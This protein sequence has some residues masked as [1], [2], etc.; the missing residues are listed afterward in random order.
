MSVPRNA[1]CPCGSG[2]KYK[3]CCLRSGGVEAKRPRKAAALIAGIAVVL[4]IVLG[5]VVGRE[6]GGLVGAVGLVIAGLY[7]WLAAPPASR[8]GGDPGAIRFGS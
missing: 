1:P 8:A 3:R 4:G 6:V 7:L 2:K 5:L